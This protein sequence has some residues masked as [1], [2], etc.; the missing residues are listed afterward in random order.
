MISNWW[1]DTH[2]LEKCIKMGKVTEAMLPIAACT[3]R[4][5]YIQALESYASSLLNKEE[6][7]LAAHYFHLSG[8]QDRAIEVLT[9]AK[10]YREA[11][12]MMK[13]ILPEEDPRIK[14]VMRQWAQK[15]VWDGNFELAAKIFCAISDFESAM[16]A[17]EKRTISY[18]YKS[19]IYIAEQAKDES[20]LIMFGVNF[21]IDG[22]AKGVYD[23]INSLIEKYPKLKVSSRFLWIAVL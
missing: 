19:G 21:V 2:W 18:A 12:A 23:E 20:K 10:M 9:N 22:L 16:M 15:S 6:Y 7:L 8:K 11:V 1:G 4:V 3:N 5:L 17:I 14:E 13:S